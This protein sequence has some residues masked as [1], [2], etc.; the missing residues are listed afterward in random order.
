MEEDH[1]AG[2][3]PALGGVAQG[4]VWPRDP[5][6]GDDQGVVAGPTIVLIKININKYFIGYNQD[7]L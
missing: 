5:G 7:D 2:A 6:H 1:Q 4:S 3:G